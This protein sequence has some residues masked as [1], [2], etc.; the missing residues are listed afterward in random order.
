MIFIFSENSWYVIAHIVRRT[1]VH[2][3]RAFINYL[4]W[5]WRDV[6]VVDRDFRTIGKQMSNVILMSLHPLAFELS[7]IP[8]RELEEQQTNHTSC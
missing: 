4:M 8:R 3:F 1:G 6:T 2:P 7:A 5:I